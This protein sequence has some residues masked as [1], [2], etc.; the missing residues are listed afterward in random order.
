VQDHAVISEIASIEGELVL[1]DGKI[2]AG[3]ETFQRALA[4]AQKSGFAK[5]LIAAEISIAR[6]ECLYGSKEK[7]KELLKKR[8]DRAE[9]MGQA[10]AIA[11][12]LVYLMRVPEEKIGPVQTSRWF[13]KLR[14]FE[15]RRYE[16]EFSLLASQRA[17]R[18]GR[19]KQAK[20][21]EDYASGLFETLSSG[22]SQPLRESFRRA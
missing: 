17:T 15:L 10:E 7:G 12:C 5:A 19:K 21:Y 4:A 11:R 20:D 16:L 2:E 22:L 8:L 9:E 3:K 6:L 13:E 14:E 1:A 18:E